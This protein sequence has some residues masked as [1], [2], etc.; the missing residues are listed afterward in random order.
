MTARVAGFVSR[1]DAGL[2]AP[3]S[4]SRNLDPSRGGVALHYGGGGTPT[5]HGG[6]VSTW[7]GWQDY[8]LSRGW[9]DIAYSFGFC[10]H[11]YV[12]AGRGFGTRTAANG[13][14]SG[15][16]S[17]YAA[18]WIG[19][20]NATPSRDAID[21]VEWI[22]KAARDE[23]SAGTA[24]RP[25]RW[26]KSTGCPGDALTVTAARLHQ[27]SITVGPVEPVTPAPGMRDYPVRSGDTLWNI[28]E[29]AYGDPDLWELI[30][31]SNP[32]TLQ[33]SKTLAAGMTLWLPADVPEEYLMPSLTEID[34]LLA[35][36]LAGLPG[37]TRD[38]I[39]GARIGPVQAR[40][41]SDTVEAY[42]VG[43]GQLN[44]FRD[45]VRAA[46]QEAV[47]AGKTP[48]EAADAAVDALGAGK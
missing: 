12:F 14:N 16:D 38:T 13:T 39:L 23:G 47:E 2:R 4:R 34:K 48:D 46:V 27:S 19:G 22:V 17:F 43:N 21:A 11:G 1:A 3:R 37:S 25:H 6:C 24:V 42:L 32:K 26:F 41:V 10:Q 31:D 18:C 15:N 30:F 36:R 29:R 20:T 8:H 7:R 33:G 28:A 9:A 5:S 45:L 44:K 35:D 40:G